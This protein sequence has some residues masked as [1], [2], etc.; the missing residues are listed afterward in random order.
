MQ[1]YFWEHYVDL[2]W[3]KPA[4]AHE[5]IPG[6]PPGKLPA[7]PPE[8]VYEHA[9]KGLPRAVMFRDSYATWLIPLLAE[10]FSHIRSSWQYTFDYEIVE[11]E[12]PDVVIQEMVE[13]ALMADTPQSP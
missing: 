9:D 1:P 10:N 2:K 6:P 7:R 13:R 5:V 12:H 4:L 3:I 8:I 11:Q